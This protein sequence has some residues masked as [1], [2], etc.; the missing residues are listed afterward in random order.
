MANHGSVTKGGTA[1]SMDVPGRAVSCKR[2]TT[3]PIWGVSRSLGGSRVTVD[4]RRQVAGQCGMPAGK[5]RR[6]GMR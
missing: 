3:E 6:I 1:R 4:D 2:A 5:V